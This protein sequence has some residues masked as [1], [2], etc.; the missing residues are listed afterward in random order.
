MRFEREFGPGI[1]F[2]LIPVLPAFRKLSIAEEVKTLEMLRNDAFA[3]IRQNAQSLTDV[4]NQYQYMHGN[5]AG[6]LHYL[7]DLDIPANFFVTATRGAVNVGSTCTRL[8]F[9][10]RKCL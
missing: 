8:N 3:N 2:F 7:L 10:E 9:R 6:N 1:T 4:R 5:S